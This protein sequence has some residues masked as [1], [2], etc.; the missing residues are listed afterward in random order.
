[1]QVQGTCRI[2]LWTG[3]PSTSE[4]DLGRSEIASSTMP[5]CWQLISPANQTNSSLYW[6]L[7]RISH[8]PGRKVCRTWTDAGC[9]VNMPAIHPSFIPPHPPVCR[10]GHQ[11]QR[12]ARFS[13]K[14]VD[15]RFVS[16][17]FRVQLRCAC[18]TAHA[19]PREPAGLFSKVR[20]CRSRLGSPGPWP[21]LCLACR[22]CTTD[23]TTSS[24][25]AEPRHDQRLCPGAV[26][27]TAQNLPTVE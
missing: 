27:L 5:M 11:T 6:H 22:A 23:C 8:L 2:G 21:C 19:V 13:A 9:R 10:A 17:R 18:R 26:R 20:Q 1:M 7:A 12:Q 25:Q 4:F 24:L 15:R 14:G 3:R 16:L